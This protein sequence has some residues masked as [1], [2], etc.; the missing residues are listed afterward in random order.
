M[1]PDSARYAQLAY[2]YLGDDA[3]TARR[4]A[5]QLYC[6]DVGKHVGQTNAARLVPAPEGAAG[7]GGTGRQENGAATG[8]LAHHR[9]AA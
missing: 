7:H 4:Q 9:R 6:D 3:T 5:T 2:E 8:R 1:W